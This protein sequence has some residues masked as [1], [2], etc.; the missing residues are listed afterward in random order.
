MKFFGFLTL[1]ILSIFL[2]SCESSSDSVL[3]TDNSSIISVDPAK[4]LLETELDIADT[5]NIFNVN[6]EIDGSVGGEIT[7]DTV[8][9]DSDGNEVIIQAA[10]TF[11]P[12]SFD[13][14]KSISISPDPANGSIT[15]T[16]AIKFNIPAILDLNF[17]GINLTRL[18]FDSNTKVDFVYRADDGTSEFILKNECKIK[19]NTQEL[20]V[21]KA[22]LP[23][24]SRYVFV[25]KSL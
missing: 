4:S 11:S 22:S 15:F 5:D 16:P 21:K 1:I 20:Y 18:G 19:W 3:S 24:F 7:L 10:I 17:K 9:T 12:N 8:Y 25:R 2:I 13:G 23:H 6:K 14:I